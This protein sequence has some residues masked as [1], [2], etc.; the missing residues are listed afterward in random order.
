MRDV[1]RP[2]YTQILDLIEGRLAGTRCANTVAIRPVLRS[3]G[4]P[5]GL[6]RRMAEYLLTDKSAALRPGSPFV[7]MRMGFPLLSRAAVGMPGGA[8][9]A[10]SQPPAT[11]PAAAG[12]AQH[13][14]AVGQPR[15]AISANGTSVP[16]SSQRP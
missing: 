16:G 6:T 15:R 3:S 11:A 12:E 9:A 13:R 4:R 14:S 1:D 5:A 7:V 2:P 8:A 10:I